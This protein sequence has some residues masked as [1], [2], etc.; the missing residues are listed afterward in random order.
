MPRR[1]VRADAVYSLAAE[2]MQGMAYVRAP[3]QFVVPCSCRLMLQSHWLQSNN[4]MLETRPVFLKLSVTV[5]RDAD[6]TRSR[7]KY[8]EMARNKRLVCH[9]CCLNP[10]QS[11]GNMLKVR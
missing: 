4:E 11:F 10:K 1:S 6:G 9:I 3:S 5:V 8:K 7:G 2:E